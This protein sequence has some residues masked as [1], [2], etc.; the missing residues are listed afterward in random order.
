MSSK[1]F[2]ATFICLLFLWLLFTGTFGGPLF[3]ISQLNVVIPQELFAGAVIA[4]IVGSVSYGYFTQDPG[5]MIN[6]KRWAY[7]IA[8][9]PA[10]I[11]SEIKSHLLVAYCVLNPSLPIRPAIVELPTELRS[12]VGLTS[13]ADSITM[14]PGTLTVDIDEERPRL[15][16]HW[17]TA[18]DR[19][20]S[21]VVREEVGR[22]FERFL[23]GGFG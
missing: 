22:Q 18:G 2:V 19:I 4:A 10:Y 9:V 23:K 20:E 21:E 3:E 1:R 14:T 11:W 6:P 7:Y 13:L 15:F 17:I 12:D 5:A 16:V 8:Y